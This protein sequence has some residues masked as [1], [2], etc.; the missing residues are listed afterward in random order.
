MCVKHVHFIPFY[1]VIA[2]G[3]CTV[4]RNL[5]EENAVLVNKLNRYIPLEVNKSI[6][7]KSRMC[8]Y[9]QGVSLIKCALARD[10]FVYSV[11]KVLITHPIPFPHRM[12]FSYTLMHESSVIEYFLLWR[13][14]THGN[15]LHP[16][17]EAVMSLKHT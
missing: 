15:D 4:N 12:P 11:E 16:I 14:K 1:H 9:S 10:T 6:K 13:L 7:G 2:T 3:N 5:F 8:A 17:W